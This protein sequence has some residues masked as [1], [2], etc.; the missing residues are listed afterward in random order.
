MPIDPCILDT[1][2]CESGVGGDGKDDEYMDGDIREVVDHFLDGASYQISKNI[3]VTSMIC[4]TMA[5]S[6][7]FWEDMYKILVH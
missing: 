6:V 5:A 2:M 4:S 3:L 7:F 1:P